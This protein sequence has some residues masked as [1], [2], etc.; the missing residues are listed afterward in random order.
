MGDHST[1]DN[2]NNENLPSHYEE[3]DLSDTLGKCGHSL[4]SES[5]YHH[6]D[7]LYEEVNIDPYIEEEADP[8]EI[9]DGFLNTMTNSG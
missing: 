3:V 2:N 7:G 4:Q 6:D 5:R 9:P 1:F 8:Y